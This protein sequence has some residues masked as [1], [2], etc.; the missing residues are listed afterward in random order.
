MQTLLDIYQA[1]F[2]ARWRCGC[3]GVFLSVEND[4]VSIDTYR[5]KRGHMNRIPVIIQ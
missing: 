5:C 4:Q 2:L 3:C 1:Q